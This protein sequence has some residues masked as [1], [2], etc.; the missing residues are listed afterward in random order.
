MAQAGHEKTKPQQD[1]SNARLWVAVLL[2]VFVI[3]SIVVPKSIL[4]RFI[5]HLLYGLFFQFLPNLTEPWVVL[6]QGVTYLLLG[7][8]FLRSIHR[9]VG[10]LGANADAWKTGVPWGLAMFLAS[11]VLLIGVGGAIA[12]FHQIPSVFWSLPAQAAQM[13]KGLGEAL[14]IQGFFQS[15]VVLLTLRYL[16]K[17]NIVSI[18]GV[19]AATILT[20]IMQAPEL[21]RSGLQGITLAAALVH[22]SLIF[23]FV[24]SMTYAITNNLVL[25]AMLYGGYYAMSY[26]TVSGVY[27]LFPLHIYLATASAVLYVALKSNPKALHETPIAAQVDLATSRKE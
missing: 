3:Q 4:V 7:W 19:G 13:F 17:N 10:T 26:W 18:F 11:A 1:P 12:G 22:V 24:V 2:F 5:N 9:P 6:E 16:K 25:A 20:M 14:C 8:L 23:G 27:T 21:A 15:S